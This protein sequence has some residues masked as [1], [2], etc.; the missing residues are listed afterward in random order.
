MKINTNDQ[1]PANPVEMDDVNNVTMKIL[2]GLPEESDNIIMR[3]FK[4]GPGGHTPRHRH[5]YEH[6]VKIESNRGILVDEEGNEHEIRKGQSVFVKPNELHQFRNPY[7][8][9]F[10]FICIIPN[11]DKK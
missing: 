7:N 4:I 8:E 1:I 2:I 10:E 6:V 9:D 3:Q 5:N 11:P